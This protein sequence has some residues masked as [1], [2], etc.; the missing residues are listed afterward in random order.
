MSSADSSRFHNWIKMFLSR[1]KR[2]D[3]DRRPTSCSPHHKS[4]NC[5]SVPIRNTNQKT[6]CSQFPFSLPMFSVFVFL[7]HPTPCSFSKFITFRHLSLFQTRAPILLL[8]FSSPGES[9]QTEEPEFV[10]LHA[11]LLFQ[12]NTFCQRTRRRALSAS[13]HFLVHNIFKW[14]SAEFPSTYVFEIRCSV[15]RISCFSLFTKSVSF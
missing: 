6:S 7:A 2:R 8:R 14:M 5:G 4:N 3:A 10:A 1:K 11:A 9:R 12:L 15:K 13:E